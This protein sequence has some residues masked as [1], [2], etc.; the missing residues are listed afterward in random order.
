MGAAQKI[1]HAAYQG[2]SVV[3]EIMIGITLGLMAGGLWKMHHW[4]NQ[5]RSRE[6]YN[7]LDKGLI[8]V[9]VEDE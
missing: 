1:G 2:P 3:K 4:N 5:K 9:V 8:S 6:F 7:M